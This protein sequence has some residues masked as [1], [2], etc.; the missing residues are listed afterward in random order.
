MSKVKKVCIVLAAPSN[1][2]KQDIFVSKMCRVYAESLKKKGIEVDLID[3]YKDVEKSEFQLLDY[4]EGKDAKVSEY[5]LRIKGADMLVVFYAVWWNAIPAALKGFLE[6]VFTH[7]FAYKII[8]RKVEGQLDG[9][10]A[11]VFVFDDRSSF[12]SKMFFNNDTKTF[13][14][15]GIFRNCDLNGKLKVFS[16]LFPFTDD[17]AIKIERDIKLMS[18]KLNSGKSVLDLL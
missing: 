18:E 10:R 3:I 6:R 4:S 12:E 9:K 2:T 15:K 7:P 8:S 5:Q 17:K 13:W 11:R 14:Q 16:R 1:G